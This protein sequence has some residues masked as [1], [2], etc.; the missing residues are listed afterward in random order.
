MAG[1]YGHI[2]NDKGQFIGVELLGNSG[3]TYEAVEE[4]YGMIWYLANGDPK[5]VA[6]AEA[7]YQKGLEL[8]ATIERKD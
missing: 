8:A 1:S 5:K 4:M 6:E 2:T 3:D 7:N